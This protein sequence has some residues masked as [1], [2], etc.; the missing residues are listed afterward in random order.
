MR[1]R[2]ER[3]REIGSATA[4][5]GF[6][7]EEDVVNRFNNWATDPYARQWLTTMGYNLDEIEEVNAIQLHGYKTDVQVQV[8]ITMRRA[9][10]VENLSVK[11]V[12][13]PQGYNQ[14]DKRWVDAYRELWNIPEGVVRLLKMY[15]GEI[16]PANLRGVRDRRRMFLTEMNELDQREIVNFFTR[17]MILVISDLLRGRGDFAAGWMLVILKTNGRIRWALRNMNNVMNIF[18]RGDVA[19]TNRGSLRIGRITMQ[20]KGGDAGRETANMLQFKINPV[21]IFDF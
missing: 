20:R 8:T 16:T 14:I 1:V 15:T 17:N 13:N 7:N 11:L 10:S 12:S 18:G 3:L 2:Q 5:G 6:R 21:D 19:I 9:I 4:R